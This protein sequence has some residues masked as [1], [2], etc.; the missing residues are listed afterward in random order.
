MSTQ[1]TQEPV[2]VTLRSDVDWPAWCSRAELT[3][4]LHET[5][6]PYE[7]SLADIDNAIDY[8]FSKEKY[9]GGFILLV[10]VE[11]KLGGAV[12]MLNTGM[13]G[14]IPENVLVFVSIDPSLRGQGIGGE[15]IRRSIAECDGQV[16][17][18]VDFGNPARRLYE[19]LGFVHAYDEMRY[20]P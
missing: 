5:M 11:G 19:R 2:Y 3:I 18:H 4:F 10:G 6:K 9:A 17:L 13:A 14:Y 16:K 20:K 12:V 1:G 8:A 7:D 15:L